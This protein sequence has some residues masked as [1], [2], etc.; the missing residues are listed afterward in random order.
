MDDLALI[1]FGNGDGTFKQPVNMWNINYPEFSNSYVDDFN[2]DGLS[3][4]LSIMD[5]GTVYVMLSGLGPQSAT[6]TVNGVYVVGT[7]THQVDASYS[8]DSDYRPSISATIPLTAEPVANILNLSTSPTTSN[9]SDPV[10][11]TA[12][13]V[14]DPSFYSWQNHLPTG[15]VSFSYGTSTLSTGTLASEVATLSTSGL[16]VGADN[17]TATYSGDTNFATSTAT[18]FTETVKAYG[19]TTILTA[20]PNPANAGQTITLTAAVAEIGTLYSPLPTGSVTF[21]N[22]TTQLTTVA[23]DATG[24]ASYSSVLPFGN[25]SFTA[26]Y[27]GDAAYSP[28]T[29]T[30][31]SETVNGYHSTTILTPT[32][33]PAGTGHVVTLAVTVAEVGSLY[34]TL[35]AGTVTL[36]DGATPLTTL[37]L[38]ATAHATYTTSTL[39]LGTHPLT[40]VYAGNTSYYPSTSSTVN[41][42]LVTPDFSL[43]LSSPSITLQTY[44]HTTTTVTL[45]SVGEFADSI[46]LACANLPAYVTCIFTPSTTA[47]ASDGS[48]TISFYLDTDSD[49]GGRNGPAV[50]IGP[51]ALLGNSP[52]RGQTPPSRSPINLAFLL[53]PASL[54]VALAAR[55]RLRSRS[56]RARSSSLLLLLLPATLTLPALLALASCGGSIITQIPSAA[57]GTYTIPITATGATGLTH[58]AQITLVVT[59]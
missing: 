15:S 28:S 40:A 9:Y 7:G 13:L 36:Y 33:N 34:S 47:L 32:P 35:P 57:P 58:T 44:Q 38:D 30:P 43:T 10:Q 56:S 16:P 5:E 45:A 31:F 12:T 24:R 59:P 29:S 21:Y 48:A 17:I 18:A 37:T 50:R 27:S 23:L 49:L 4:I 14:H 26:S 51:T 52:Q 46:T 25:Y 8:G 55:R 42:V 2:G 20:S 22:G 53:S 3:D 1:E 6:A 54:F 11:L 39:T 41:E 19:T